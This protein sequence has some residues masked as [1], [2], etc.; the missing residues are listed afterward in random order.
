MLKRTL[1]FVFGTSLLLASG[2]C[3]TSKS[4]ESGD[5]PRTTQGALS[6]EDGEKSERK[7]TESAKK[8]EQAKKNEKAE[9]MRADKG[10]MRSKRE[11]MA[12]M[13]PMQVE[14]TTRNV[15]KLDNAVAMD[16]TTTGDVDEVRSRVAKMATKHNKMHADGKSM[17]KGKGKTKGKGKMKGKEKM[18]GK[19]KMAGKHKERMKMMDGVSAKAS[20]IDGG[21]RLTLTPEDPEKADQIFKMMKEH[22]GNKGQCP[23]MGG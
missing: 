11:K 15:V 22:A 6:A 2:G 1:V 19:G 12:G 5:S 17:K 4:A 7:T 9:K 18:D 20:D 16:F 10:E 14:G 21:A 8:A 3:S 23:M 13:C